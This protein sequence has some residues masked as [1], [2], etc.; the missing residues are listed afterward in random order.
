MENQTKKS[1]FEG[2]T[3]DEEKSKRLVAGS[4]FSML[5]TVFGGL[6]MA[7]LII[8]TTQLLG[9]RDFGLFGPIFQSFW[10]VATII[11]LG[12]NFAMTTYV[13]HHWEQD[14]E[15]ARKFA[16]EGNKL[17][18]LISSG[19]TVVVILFSLIV[20][21]LGKISTFHLMLAIIY[22][23]AVFTTLQFWSISGIMLG[24]QRTDYYAL[25]NFIFPTTTFLFSLVFVVAAQKLYGK[26][27]ELDIVGAVAGLILGGAVTYLVVVYLLRRVDLEIYKNLYNFKVNYGIYGKI[28]KFGGVTNI[29]NISFTLF[30][31][32]PCVLIGFLAMKYSIFAPSYELNKIISGYFSSSYIYASAAMMIMGLV[33]PLISAMSEAEGQKKFELMQ[34]Y[35]DLILKYT[36]VILVGCFIFYASVGGQIVNLLAGSE[37]P[38]EKVGPITVILSLGICFLGLFYLFMNIF[39]GVK[40]P[41]YAAVAVG[42]GVVLQIFSIIL[43]SYFFKDIYKVSLFFSGSAIITFLFTLFFMRYYVK[44]KIKLPLVIVPLLGGGIAYLIANKYI[45]KDGFLF[46]PCAGVLLTIY[47]VL[48]VLSDKLYLEKITDNKFDKI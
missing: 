2:A 20:F 5:A 27:S 40:K 33:W 16:I 11:S 48:F 25:G 39:I 31:S 42:S 18:L 7:G 46:L 6:F 1:I 44:L 41:Q 14:K 28:I 35:F 24:L 26:Q 13:A 19:F 43:S 9:A 36:L 37:Y 4:I 8:S 23:L 45:P 15:E 29:A 21:K 32:L 22:T 38:V 47:S 30:N 34:H 17:L 12:L 3:T 10:A